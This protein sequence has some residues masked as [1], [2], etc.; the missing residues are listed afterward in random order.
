[1]PS[2]DFTRPVTPSIEDSSQLPEASPFWPIA[3]TLGEIAKRVERRQTE[4]HSD[5]VVPRSSR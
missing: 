1:M 5:P 3:V 2:P 4:E